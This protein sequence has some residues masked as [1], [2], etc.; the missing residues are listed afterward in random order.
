MKLYYKC[1]ILVSINKDLMCYHTST[2]SS[3]ELRVYLEENLITDYHIENDFDP[4]YHTNSFKRPLLPT[5]L[6]DALF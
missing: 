1:T 6:A 5:T 2:P 4:I 3:D